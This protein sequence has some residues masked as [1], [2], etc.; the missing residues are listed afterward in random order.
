MKAI[1][2][3]QE[4][5]N[6]TTLIDMTW[7]L[8]EGMP[9]WPTQ[10][11]FT[12]E[13]KEHQ[14]LGCESYWRNIAFCE[15]TGT[16]MDAG[17]HFV[18]GQPSIDRTPVEQIMGRGV[19]I[20]VTDTPPCGYAPLSKVLE[21]EEKYG[22][23]QE[24]DIVFFRFGWDEKWAIGPEGKDYLTDWPGIHPDIGKYLLTR[25][26]KAVGCDTLA[27]DAFGSTNPN[28]P[29]LLG[30][31]VNILENVN[32]LGEL[33]P[34]FGVIGLPCKFKAGSGATIR[35]VALIDQEEDGKEVKE[36]GT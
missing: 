17:C 13:T 2:K 31:G 16:H 21:F 20:D 28:H 32:K 7:T 9:Y 15:H 4:L 1:K 29:I 11:P 10:T 26:V 35:L 23:I 5:L 25:K 8:E 22:R 24:G 36:I 19:N 14:S 30:N 34:F 12:A 33:P 3:L 18:P 27:L 6:T